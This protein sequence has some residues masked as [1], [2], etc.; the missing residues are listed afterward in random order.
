MNKVCAAYMK[1]NTFTDGDLLQLGETQHSNTR[2]VQ[3]KL[4]SD[5]VS[6]QL[7]ELA[8]T[9]SDLAIRKIKKQKLSPSL[10]INMKRTLYASREFILGKS[11]QIARSV[12]VRTRIVA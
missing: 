4:N 8:G 9:V 10:Q 7:E 11:N 2:K 5:K 6:A 12:F 1:S 3:D